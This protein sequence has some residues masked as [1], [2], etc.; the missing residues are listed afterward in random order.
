MTQTAP[1]LPFAHSEATRHMAGQRGQAPGAGV[2]P[3]PLAHLTAL[4][5]AAS[6]ELRSAG[7]T[8]G[9]GS[10]QR[11][12]WVSGFQGVLRSVRARANQPTPRGEGLG[13][14]CPNVGRRGAA[15]AY[16][17]LF[18]QGVPHRRLRVSDP[19]A[20][21]APLDE[22]LARVDL[23]LGG[24]FPVRHAQGVNDQSCH[25]TDGVDQRHQ[26]Q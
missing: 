7:K 26:C 19:S 13:G 21:R 12:C 4:A 25:A 23:L 2:L 9:R 24:R 3:L 22:L 8:R 1:P 10:R 17:Q 15:A 11:M 6:P 14:V 5:L 18:G 16:V 20:D